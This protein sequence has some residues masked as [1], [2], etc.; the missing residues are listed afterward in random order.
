MSLTKETE[1]E[2][3]W[4]DARASLIED[5]S[6][7]TLALNAAEK[8]EKIDLAKGENYGFGKINKIKKHK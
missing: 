5:G 1:I 8:F 4:R 2:M 7:E 6:N 3:I